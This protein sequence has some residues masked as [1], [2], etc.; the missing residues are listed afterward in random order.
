MLVPPMLCEIVQ[1]LIT[2]EYGFWVIIPQVGRAGVF[3]SR[4]GSCGGEVAGVL[5]PP[6]GG[7]KRCTPDELTLLLFQW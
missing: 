4:G 5:A 7:E 2:D 3:Y 6:W 1:Y